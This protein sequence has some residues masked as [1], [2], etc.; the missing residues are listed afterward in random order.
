VKL[1][2][3]GPITGVP[4]GNRPAFKAA[5]ELL[6]ER[7]FRV[8]NPSLQEHEGWDWDRYMRRDIRWLMRCDGVAAIP[9]WE[10]SRGACVEVRLALDL[11]MAVRHVEEWL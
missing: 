10:F 11:G 4:D 1:Y 2:L 9:G 7:G 3:S 8:V 5:A 6:R